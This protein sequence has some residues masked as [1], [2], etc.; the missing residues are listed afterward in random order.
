M[1]TPFQSEPL[2]EDQKPK[3]LKGKKAI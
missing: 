1:E 3:D 2:H